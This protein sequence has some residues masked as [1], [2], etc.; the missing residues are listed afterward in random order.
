MSL[1]TLPTE[2]LSRIAIHL[3]P[4]PQDLNSLA[5]ASKLLY[6]I[7]NPILY[8]HQ[9]AHQNSTALIWASKH[10]K[11]APCTRLLHQGANPNTQD[12]QSRTPLSWAAA[13]GHRELVSILLSSD[14][15][16]PNMPD[17]HLQTPLVWAAGHGLYSPFRAWKSPS[18]PGADADGDT[19]H[20]NTK[21]AEY[22]A[23]V[24]LL[25]STRAIQP[26]RRTQR[27][28]TPLALAAAAGAEDIV[29]ELLGTGKVNANSSDK[30][31]QSALMAAA[32]SGH[33]RIVTRLLD[34]GV[35]PDARS[36]SG[37][38]ALLAA[39]RNG[40]A[41]VVKVLLALRTVDPEHEPSFGDRALVEAVGAGH[42]DV[43][44]LLLSSGRVDPGLSSKRGV[45]G[46]GRAAQRGR[47]SI[48]R[49][50]LE[51]GV[52]A[53]GAD[54]EGRTPVMIAAER[55]HVEVVRLLLSTGRVR[56]DFDLAELQRGR[57]S[58]FARELN[59]DVVRVLDEYKRRRGGSLDS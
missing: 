31:G 55:G 36:S 49:L 59:G 25:L 37:D 48:M 10:G 54:G 3:L 32:R 35:D 26:D 11:P 45:T 51:R 39:A 18:P 44:R 43:V 21:A 6:T 42:E 58:F 20:P 1:L 38:S 29:E 4:S 27:G 7:T 24:K 17:A 56:A 13:N 46:L 30:F 50:L 57:E 22:L 23:I 2:L 34:E 41:A 33:V 53:D 16:D 52:E 40:H 12:A 8:N 28:E 19:V 47:T 9:I 14:K 5:K 15:I